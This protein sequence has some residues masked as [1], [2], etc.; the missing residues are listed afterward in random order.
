MIGAGIWTVFGGYWRSMH[1]P[2]VFAG[3]VSLERFG[4]VVKELKER[5]GIV[6][7]QAE[8]QADKWQIVWFHDDDRDRF[9]FRAARSAAFAATAS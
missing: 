5:C 2:Y 3:V 9:C 4:D 7:A 6:V 8:G 1:P